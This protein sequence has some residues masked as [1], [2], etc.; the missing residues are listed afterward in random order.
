MNQSNNKRQMGGI[1]LEV[2]MLSFLFA[3]SWTD[4]NGHERRSTEELTISVSP[5][6]QL[7]FRDSDSSSELIFSAVSKTF[8][9]CGKIL[10]LDFDLLG[11]ELST[12]SALLVSR[13]L[14]NPFYTTTFIGAP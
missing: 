7:V 10:N 3:Y 12:N 4:L 14:Y 9:V 6:D 2:L 11:L 1:L 5:A 8:I 13:S